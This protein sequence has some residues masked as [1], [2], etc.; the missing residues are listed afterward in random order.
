MR[1]LSRRWGLPSADLPASPC[2]SSRIAYGIQITPQRLARVDAAEVA[3]RQLLA[4]AGI[5]SHDLRVRD[6][7]TGLRVEVDAPAVAAVRQLPALADAV[8]GAGFGAAPVTVAAF[9]SGALN[10]ALPAELR[11]R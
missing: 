10:A 2:L 7:G 1:A 8:A 4:A 9:S 3:L 11:F 5:R 6:L